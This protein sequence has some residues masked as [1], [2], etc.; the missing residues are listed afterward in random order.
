MPVF[1]KGPVS[2][3]YE[4]VG[5]GFPLLVIPGGGLEATIGG[6]ANHVFNPMT[7]FADA[8]RCIALDSRNANDGQSQGPLE[9]DRPWD[10]FSDDHL[11]LMDHLGIDKFMVMGFCI[12]G[13]FIWNLLKRAPQRV[14][15]AVL[16][17]PSGYRSD[18]PDIFYQNNISTWGPRLRE[19]R[20]EV[21]MDQ[22][23]AYLSTM[24][25]SNPDF[26]FS[27]S[28]DFVR[29]CETPVLVLPDDIPAHPYA[30]AMETALLAP[31]AQT[32]L[33]PWKENEQ[34]VQ[35]ALRH[36]RMFLNTGASNPSVAV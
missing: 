30:C 6:L 27:V 13:P 23:D 26:V 22:V 18:N 16:V 11:S 24:Y 4:E 17:H 35:L 19:R 34:K 29:N 36:I 31:N 20:P 25:R 8:F 14:V 7:E 21:T 33:Y 10:A 1:E 3:Y 15:C 32:S 9:I 28:R 2:L 5:T 12:G